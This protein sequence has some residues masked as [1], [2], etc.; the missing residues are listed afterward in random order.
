MAITAGDFDG[1]GALEL[2]VAERQARAGRVSLW[3]LN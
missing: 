3:L 1:D 2:L